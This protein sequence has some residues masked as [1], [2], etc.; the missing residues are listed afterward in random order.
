MDTKRKA[1][2]VLV[3][4][5]VSFTV[6]LIDALGDTKVSRCRKCSEIKTLVIKG[7]PCTFEFNGQVHQGTYTD[8]FKGRTCEWAFTLSTCTSQ[9]VRCTCS[10][11]R[12][13][14]DVVIGYVCT[15]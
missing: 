5:A 9:S 7:Q 1:I 14:S 11:G 10:D 12:Y 4:F 13:S 6:G 3:I 8:T 2:V 15:K